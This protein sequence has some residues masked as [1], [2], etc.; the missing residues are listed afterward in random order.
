MG[1]GAA[2]WQSQ[3]GSSY[4]SHAKLGQRET[5][6]TTEA[7]GDPSSSWRMTWCFQTSQRPYSASHLPQEPLLSGV[8]G[9][10][11]T[12]L[13]LSLPERNNLLQEGVSCSSWTLQSAQ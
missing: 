5:E 8:A 9:L 2:I 1:K 12:V 4:H 6:S 13:F 3:D 11:G 7:C 10:W